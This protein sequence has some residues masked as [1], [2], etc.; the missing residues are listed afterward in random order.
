MKDRIWTESFTTSPEGKSNSGLG[1]YIVKEIS[2]I[3]HTRCGFD[4][5]EDGVVF[6]FDFNDYSSKNEIQEY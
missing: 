1:L 6:W 5:T 2:L 4:N 3:E